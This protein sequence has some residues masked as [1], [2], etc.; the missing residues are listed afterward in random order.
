MPPPQHGGLSRDGRRLPVRRGK[1]GSIKVRR[2]VFTAGRAVDPVEPG[3]AIRVPWPA[4]PVVVV[5]RHSR[6]PC[7]NRLIA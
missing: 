1:N 6:I 5:Q 4:G 7:L 3:I 2:R